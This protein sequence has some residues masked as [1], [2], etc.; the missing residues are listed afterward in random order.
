[1]RVPGEYARP[2]VQ[3]CRT[4]LITS[5]NE[6]RL[7]AARGHHVARVGGRGP[8]APGPGGHVHGVHVNSHG[9]KPRARVRGRLGRRV[10]GNTRDSN[11][12]KSYRF[13]FD[14]VIKIRERVCELSPPIRRCSIG[15]MLRP[16]VKKLEN[17][18][19]GQLFR[20]QL[21]RPQPP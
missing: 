20:I 3:R 19:A 2:T 5:P 17:F 13:D 6:S 1:M 4:G 11:R 9:R 12:T 15:K 7:T 14:I 21:Q 18:C 16:F 8:C 10:P